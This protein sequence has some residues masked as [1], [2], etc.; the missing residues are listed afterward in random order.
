[1]HEIELNIAADHIDQRYHRNSYVFHAQSYNRDLAP[2]ATIPPVPSSLSADQIE[3]FQRMERNFGGTIVHHPLKRDIQ[4]SRLPSA[5]TFNPNYRMSLDD[6][7]YVLAVSFGE[8]R[9]SP[10]TR[11][12][13]SGGALYSGQITLYAKNIDGLQSGS[14]HY[15]PHARQLECLDAGS[16]H[17]IERHLF[18]ASQSSLIH[19]AFFI[20]Y[21][22]IP[23]QS[24][25]KYGMRGYRLACIEI[26]SMY[27]S[28][29][30]QSEKIGLRSRVWG[31]FADEGLSISM[32]I[33]PRVAWPVIC[34][35]IGEEGQ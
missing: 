5:E 6:L 13:P 15:L 35:L 30:F 17:E 28:L 26:G 31:G 16:E 9:S 18:L 10:H 32:G 14:Y 4:P 23:M 22:I 8:S 33:D 20:L 2:W 12:Y 29:I 1:M 24:I 7:L 19:Y 11:P 25:A 3:L 21:S 34:H 27:Q